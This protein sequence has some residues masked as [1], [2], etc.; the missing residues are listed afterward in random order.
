LHGESPCA[1]GQ[2]SR[3]QSSF[4]FIWAILRVRMLMPDSPG[5]TRHHAD[6]GTLR[7]PAPLRRGFLYE[8]V[9]Q[10]LSDVRK[11][12]MDYVV[13]ARKDKFQEYSNY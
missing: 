12:I 11:L 6:D 5:G 9:L 1:E 13:L 2:I 8:Q 7:I 4:S 3:S 10:I